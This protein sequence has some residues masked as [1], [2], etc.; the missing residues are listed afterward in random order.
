MKIDNVEVFLV[1]TAV[2]S[3][4]ADSTRKVESI[5]YVIVRVNTDDGLTG[6]GITYHEVGGEAIRQLIKKDLANRIIGK[7]PFETEAIWEDIF[8]F[9][10]GVARK[11]LAFCALSAIDIALWDLK[12]KILK[13]PLYKLLGGNKSRIPLYASGGWTSYSKSQLLEELQ[14]MISNGY[15]TVKLKVGVNE[16][17]SPEEDIER[18]RWIRKELGPE[19]GIMLDANNAYQSATAIRVAH[20]LDDC[21]I[22]LF[23][24]PV[25]ADDLE[26]LARVRSSIKIPVATGEH[27]YTKYGMRD[28]LLNKAVDIVQVDVTR[29]GGITEWLKIAAMAQAW[30]VV[31]AP[32]CMEYMHMHLLGAIP[33][34][35]MLERIL[36]FEP[37]NEIVFVGQPQPKD[38]FIEIPDLPGLGLALNEDNIKKLNE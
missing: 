21:N 4:I 23:E 31:M 2:K 36:T 3:G 24:E 9:M 34:G 22:Y 28:L 12:G 26:G 37:L 19:I 6:I 35:L 27:E 15:K 20:G 29:C 17:K 16:G 25:L 11:G 14:S 1:S 5:G 33:N 8:N 38:G 30:N 7:S 18:V 32:H 10:R 13:M